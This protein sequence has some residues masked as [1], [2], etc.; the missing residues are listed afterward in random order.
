M[1]KEKIEALVTGGKATAG[2]P[3]GP[4]LGPMGVNIGK[5]LAEINEKTSSMAGMQVPIKVIVDTDTKE[6]EISVGTPPTSALIKKEIGMEKGSGAKDVK[7]ADIPIDLAIKVA[8]VKQESN[9]LIHFIQFYFYSILLIS[10][11]DTRNKN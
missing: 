11:I 2:P 4:A 9:L 6:F 7:S 5:V 8:K 1:V 10:R 3:L